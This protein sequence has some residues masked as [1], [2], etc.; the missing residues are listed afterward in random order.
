MRFTHVSPVEAIMAVLDRRF[1]R[2]E[3]GPSSASAP[4]VHVEDGGLAAFQAEALERA[5]AIIARHGG[6]IIAD[7]V[8]LGKT[9]VAVALVRRYLNA[10]RSVVI[11]APAQLQMHWR[12]VLRNTRGWQ[13]ISHTSLS[14][15]VMPRC[16]SGVIVVDE[17]HAL[18]NPASRRHR[19][20]AAAA[21]RADV[22]L[23]TATPV[24]N[25]VFDFYHLVRLF[26][27]DSAFAYAGVIDL[28]AA[29]QRAADGTDTTSL[30]RVAEQVMVRR[31][32]A[33]VQSRRD[34]GL[35][36]GGRVLSFPRQ[37]PIVRIRYDLS[38]RYPLLIESVLTTL[39]S[40]TFP[41][42]SAQYAAGG[43]ATAG[44]PAELMRVAMLKRLE[45]GTGAFTA[46]LLK[47]QRLLTNF[48][49]TAREGYL[50]TPTDHRA[51]SSASG[52]ALQLIMTPL[53]LR[54]WPE[55][56]DRDRWVAEAEAELA[57]LDALLNATGRTSA[58]AT[59]DPKI[60]ALREL[61]VAQHAGKKVLV[62]TEFRDTAAELWRVLSPL[63][64]VALIHGGDARL[65]KGRAPRRV[66]IDRFAPLAN[67]A[68]APRPHEC[69][70]ILIATDVL[71]E[72]LNLQDA[73]VIVSYDVPWNPV[74]LAQRIGRVDRLGSPHE[75]I[76]ACVFM[77]D[78]GL[79]ALLRLFERVRRKL[80]DIRTVGGDAPRFKPGTLVDD[81]EVVERLRAEW[82]RLRRG[83]DF[84]GTLRSRSPLAAAVHWHG[85]AGFICVFDY[86][87]AIWTVLLRA[88]AQPR[89]GSATADR[90]LLFALTAPAGPPAADQVLERAAASARAAL[91]RHAA[92]VGTPSRRGG[93]SRAAVLVSRWV[94]SSRSTAD[95]ALRLRIADDVLTMLSHP[96]APSYS[97]IADALREQTDADR[98]TALA[99]LAAQRAAEGGDGRKSLRQTGRALPSR[100]RLLAVLELVPGRRS[101]T[102]AG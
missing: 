71:A 60:A 80:R 6:A 29:A 67:A 86:G 81:A 36:V 12:R 58:H 9:H 54:A 23:L 73:R 59:P 94:A 56:L 48:M 87:D 57:R 62:F 32:R 92:A 41:V 17:A 68:R 89:I 42:H 98:M 26:A 74:R 51:L 5:V 4:R 91:R 61:I 25:S 14:R 63:G 69:V 8:G 7:S 43:A 95:E 72:G 64:G 16:E 90:A 34:C 15:G 1:G 28:R 84:D 96:S 65:G 37:E 47:Q 97:G 21:S 20:L 46:S 30:R 102:P 33:I 52:S 93:V 27:D 38:Q 18:R 77:P 3:G 79:E 75:S 22:L 100:R 88:N 53:T 82:T 31:T 10:R 13:W 49:A 11:T 44:V 45:S 66:I 39:A 78:R 2:V 70:R 50:M 19:T 76:I 24:N 40:M 85:S 35:T 99:R 83:C 101:D 55:A